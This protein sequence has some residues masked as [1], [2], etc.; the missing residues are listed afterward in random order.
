MRDRAPLV[1]VTGTSATL[2]IPDYLVALRPV[3]GTGFR[4]L[5]TRSA[6]RFLPAESVG[7]FCSEVITPETPGVNPIELALT[8]TGIVVLPASAQILGCAALG[9]ATS[10]AATALLAAPAG[11]LFFPHM[12]RVMW[13]KDVLQ[14]HVATLRAAGHVVVDPASREGFE[15]WRGGTGQSQAMPG[16][17]QV[18]KVVGGWLPTPENLSPLGHRPEERHV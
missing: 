18:A 8:A 17:A 3:L 1:I 12:N 2:Q 7:W 10:P 16:P 4:V 14:G 6:T 13:D 5:M 9:L 15:I 11:C